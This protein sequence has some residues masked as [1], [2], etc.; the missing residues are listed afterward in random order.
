MTGSYVIV[1]FILHKD[2]FCPT[3]NFL[4]IQKILLFKLCF[5]NMLIPP[6]PLPNLSISRHI[7]TAGKALWFLVTISEHLHHSY[8]ALF[9]LEIEDNFIDSMLLWEQDGILT[10][11][12]LRLCQIADTLEYRWQGLLVL[13][14]LLLLTRDNVQMFFPLFLFSFVLVSV[15]ISFLSGL[16]FHDWLN[17]GDLPY[18]DL[19][20]WH[21]PVLLEV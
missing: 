1:H 12:I 13:K 18:V 4:T 11:I 9:V 5:I 19:Y 3:L 20:K 14:A 21:Y 8:Q 7:N 17:L 6:L 2:L 15:H 10:V 16:I